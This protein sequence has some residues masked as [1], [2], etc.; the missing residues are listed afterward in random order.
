M[1]EHEQAVEMSINFQA[2]KDSFKQVQ[3]GDVKI[4]L[5]IAANE[6]PVEFMQAEMGQIYTV[7]M[8]A[9]DEDE[10]PKVILPKNGNVAQAA[11]L[12]KD[13]LYWKFL[14]KNHS[15]KCESEKEADIIFKDLM[16]ITSKRHVASGDMA[17][18]FKRHVSGFNAW[19][20]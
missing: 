4:T 9:T 2:K 15:F 5:T 19:K 10:T 7:V 12:I 13:K 6:L 18:R 1:T 14:E 3:N 8:V 20:R 11:M 16:G 17:I